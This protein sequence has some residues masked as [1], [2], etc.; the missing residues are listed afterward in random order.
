MK[1]TK[2][3]KA[4]LMTELAISVA[5]LAIVFTAV[6]QLFYSANDEHRMARQKIIMRYEADHQLDIMRLKAAKGD[7]LVVQDFEV[8]PGLRASQGIEGLR[9]SVSVKESKTGTFLRYVSIVVEHDGKSGK[10]FKLESLI[11]VRRPK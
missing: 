8:E 5:I 2:R 9:C 1:R 10:P 3:A 6:C 11:R 4:F 7:A